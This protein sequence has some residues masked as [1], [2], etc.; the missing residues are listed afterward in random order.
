MPDI[1]LIPSEYKK[2]GLGLRVIFSKVMGI[3]LVLLILGLLIYGGLL[4]YKKGLTKQV[5]DSK[6]AIDKL[7]SR[8]NQNSENSIYVVD[9]K[10][11]A[12]ES[13]FKNHFYWSKLFTK[14][15]E[16]VVADV[17]FSEM[18]TT[19]IDNKMNLTLSGNAK[20]YT[21]LARQMVSF[22]EDKLFEKI[23]LTGLKLNESNELDFTLSLL[24]SKSI[25]ISQT[26]N[27]Q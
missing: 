27:K 6:Q 10:L 1:N 13:L 11:S 12:V 4:I 21:G 16:L 18:K 15:E 8:R 7:E 19:F 14:I 22:K 26:E 17:S 24:V 9:Q 2:R 25:L 23:D 5:T 20:T 3:V